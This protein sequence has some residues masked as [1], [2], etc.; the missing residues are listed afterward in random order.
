MPSPKVE[1]GQRRRVGVVDDGD[2]ERELGREVGPQRQLAPVEVGGGHDDAVGVD[3]AGAG[4]ADAEQRALGGGDELGADVGDE[5]DGG[6]AGGAD[7]VV[8]AAED[9][10]A[11]EVDE[12]ADDLGRLGEVETDDVAAVGVDADERGRLAD[13][14]GRVEAELLDQPVREQVADDGRHG[15]PGQAGLLGQVGA[16]PGAVTVQRPQEQA[17]VRPAGVLRR[18][19]D[20]F[21]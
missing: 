11:V 5:P 16:R 8:R 2:R 15:G 3:D 21:V 7:A 19:H 17:A 12:G 14:A 10:L 4:D 1:F 6:V 18:R 9:D 13:A 20:L